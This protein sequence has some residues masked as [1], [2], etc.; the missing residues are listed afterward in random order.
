LNITLRRFAILFLFII[1]FVSLENLSTPSLA[2]TIFDEWN[3]SSTT[4]VRT[5]RS[6]IKCPGEIYQ[7][8]NRI[9]TGLPDI[10]YPLHDKTSVVT[11]CSRICLGDKKLISARFLLD[12]PSGAF[13]W[14]RCCVGIDPR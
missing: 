4:N 3:T 13:E 12:N 9:Y 2:R 10:D 5:K 11:R 6:A 7:P 14:R 1:L 8:S